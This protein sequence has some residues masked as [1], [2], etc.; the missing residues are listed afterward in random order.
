MKHIGKKRSGCPKVLKSPEEAHVSNMSTF[1][2]IFAYRWITTI[3]SITVSISAE[4][5]K[6]R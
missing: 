2:T 1:D 4:T 6:V 3:R 5:T